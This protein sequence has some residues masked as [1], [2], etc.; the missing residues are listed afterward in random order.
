MAKKS[1]PTPPSSPASNSGSRSRSHRASSGKVETGKSSAGGS[2]LE[3]LDRQL[4]ELLARRVQLVAS[5][6]GVELGANAATPAAAEPVTAR[7]LAE[8]QRKMQE[9]VAGAAD[10]PGLSKAAVGEL[11]RHIASVCLSTTRPPRIAYLGPQYSYSHLAAVKCFG[12]AA[13]LIPVASIGAVFESIIRHDAQAGVVPIE[14]ST[15]GRVV[16]TL[17]MFLKHRVRICG[18][19][20][21]PIHHYLLSRTPRQEIVEVYSKPQALSQ[22]R[23]WLA[24]NLPLA[25]LVEMSST[26]AAAQLA[27]DRPGAAAIASVEAGRQYGLDVIDAAIEDNPNNVTR[28][29]LLGTEPTER[30]GHDK[31]ALLFQVHHRPGALADAM[32]LFKRDGL[33]LTW[34]ESFPVPGANSEY[35]FFIEL[36]GHES[37][38]PVAH[39]IATLGKKAERLEVLG[40]YPR[41]GMK[42]AATR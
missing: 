13:G 37:D 35:L 34:I 3:K 12:D 22:C 11:M 9:F 31:T 5:H 27:A 30:T 17:G 41:C 16:D 25:R 36:E 10:V 14:N 38:P 29:A 26:A 8:E 40:S 19:L 28:F 15:D 18:E 4:I 2:E 6:R 33:N 1:P 21:L 23:D 24:H 32:T 39:A 7:T 20:L 42:S